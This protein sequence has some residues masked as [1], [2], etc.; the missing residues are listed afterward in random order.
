MEEQEHC[1]AKKKKNKKTV[2]FQP[3]LNSGQFQCVSHQEAQITRKDGLLLCSTAGQR[4][5]GQVGFLVFIC[6]M[7]TLLLGILTN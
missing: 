2:F 7:S 3:I 1:S 5:M 6:D 4:Q